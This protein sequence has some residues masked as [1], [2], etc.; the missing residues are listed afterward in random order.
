MPNEGL[1]KG[2]IACFYYPVGA[3]FWPE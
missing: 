2:K 1:D 3:I